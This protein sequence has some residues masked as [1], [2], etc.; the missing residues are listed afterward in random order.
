M[1]PGMRTTPVYA[2]IEAGFRDRIMAG[3]LRPGERLPSESEIAREHGACRATVQRAMLRLAEGGWVERSPGR[4]TFV[5]EPPLTLPIDQQRAQ[6]FEEDVAGQG[7][8]VTFRLL[9]LGRVPAGPGLAAA[10]GCAP[11][12][13]VL[14][15]ERQRLLNGRVACL[16]RRHFA[17][18]LRADFP[19]SA[20]ETVP[21]YQLLERHLKRRTARLDVVLRAVVADEA[22]AAGL[23]VAP[24]APVML[25]E[26][27]FV[28]EAEERLIAG[29]SYYAEP[30]AFRYSA[31]RPVADG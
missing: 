13:Q 31:V 26:H 22:L 15:L 30:F 4:G 27:L 11:G 6:F 10:L 28:G 9:S 14:R 16:E 12:E 19:A 7:G 18:F 20:L 21:I 29:R 17:P 1:A 5:A 25:R 23:N 24:G 3:S 8:Q 2:R